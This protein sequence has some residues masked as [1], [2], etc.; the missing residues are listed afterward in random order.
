M[1]KILT[2][3][4]LLATTFKINAQN[5]KQI[6]GSW[7]IKKISFE[8]LEIADDDDGALKKYVDLFE[9]AILKVAKEKHKLTQKEDYKM[10]KEDKKELNYMATGF[11]GSSFESVIYFKEKNI[12]KRLYYF[13]NMPINSEGKYT[14]AVNNLK[15]TTKDYEENLEIVK[16]NS[17]ELIIKDA[18]IKVFYYYTKAKEL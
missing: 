15:I 17:T 6:I 13:D 14:I 2:I 4:L 5:A 1:K 16:I 9:K 18:E 12:F 8:N 3:C 11:A 7:E 10:T